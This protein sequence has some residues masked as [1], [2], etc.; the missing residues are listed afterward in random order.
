[1]ATKKPTVGDLDE[2]MDGVEEQLGSLAESVSRVQRSIHEL[3]EGSQEQSQRLWSA[4]GGLGGLGALDG[5]AGG[6]ADIA[7]AL[8]PVRQF[9]PPSTALPLD[10]GV[11]EALGGIRASLGGDRRELNF[12]RLAT[13][14][15]GR[16]A[17]IGQVPERHD[18]PT[19][20]KAAA[21]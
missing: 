5:I 14:W 17:F 16:V 20:G 15:D 13:D 4:L 19:T 11:A 8:G 10:P 12:T 2:R 6:L 9:T 3:S 7:E 18:T 1:M 21:P